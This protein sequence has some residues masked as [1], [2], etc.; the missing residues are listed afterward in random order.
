L[1]IEKFRLRIS[2]LPFTM[3]PALIGPAYSTWS[4]SHAF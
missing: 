2:I 1:I 4:Q 3:Y